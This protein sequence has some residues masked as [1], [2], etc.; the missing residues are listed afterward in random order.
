MPDRV[1][2]LVSLARLLSSQGIAQANAADFLDLLAT[3]DSQVATA[4]FSRRDPATWFS[5][6]AVE[7]G[8]T[9]QALAIL[10]AGQAR[11][12]DS[13][14]IMACLGY[15]SQEVKFSVSISDIQHLAKYL[16]APDPAVQAMVMELLDRISRAGPPFPDAT[17]REA[18]NLLDHFQDHS[19][20]LSTILPPNLLG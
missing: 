20:S 16:L 1:E 14:I 3:G 10:V 12:M 19:K 17:R 9:R 8:L 11:E 13:R 5:T 18:E 6:I 15:I 7:P 4:I 2:L